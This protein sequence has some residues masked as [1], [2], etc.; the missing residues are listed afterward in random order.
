[1]LLRLI[2]SWL[3]G[4]FNLNLNKNTYREL[5]WDYLIKFNA[6]WLDIKDVV[7]VVLRYNLQSAFNFSF[8]LNNIS[9]F[10]SNLP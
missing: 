3:F 10:L 2:K 9:F 8:S 1:M 6:P 4:L 5:I 7:F